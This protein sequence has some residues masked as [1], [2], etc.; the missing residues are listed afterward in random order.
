MAIRFIEGSPGNVASRWGAVREE[1]REHPGVWA[2]IDRA[3][4]GERVR[5]ASAAQ[6]LAGRYDDIQASVRTEGDEV[7]LYAQAVAR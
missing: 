5:L 2:E 6:S 3:S 4:K 7:A 1:L